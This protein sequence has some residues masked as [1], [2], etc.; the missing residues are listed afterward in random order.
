[1]QAF[2][3]LKKIIST[4]MEDKN[5]IKIGLKKNKLYTS[6]IATAILMLLGLFFI[7]WDHI[8]PDKSWIF[9]WV[10][11]FTGFVFLILS[12]SAMVNCVKRLKNKKSGLI[13]SKEGITDNSGDSIDIIRW[14]H[15]DEIKG[16]TLAGKQKFIIIFV[17]NP[18]EYIEKAGRFK[19]RLMKMNHDIYGSPLS[20]SADWFDCSHEELK[21]IIEAKCSEYKAVSE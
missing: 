14:E 9:I 20:I 6:L 2:Y 1:M 4:V 17:S 5:I 8:M 18:D 11:K 13:I 19:R 7:F 16:L 12:I 15:I 10:S 21:N 3:F